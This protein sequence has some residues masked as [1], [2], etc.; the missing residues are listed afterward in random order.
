[1]E[2]KNMMLI[3]KIIVCILGIITFSLTVTLYVKT[4]NLNFSIF[5]SMAQN[6]NYGA[7]SKVSQGT[8]LFCPD[9]QSTL[10]TEKWPGTDKG[11]FKTILIARSVCGKTGITVPPIEPISYT[12]W[13]GVPLCTERVPAKYLDLTVA[14]NENE[15][16]KEMRSCG[17]I[18]TLN[19]VM[20]VPSS[21]PC[22][23]NYMEIILD[24]QPL[25]TGFNFTII[26]MKGT[27][28][29]LSN[30]NTKGKI[31]VDMI[32]SEDIPC[33]DPYDKN[34]IYPPYILEKYFERSKCNS[35]IGNK[36]FDTDYEVKDIYPYYNVYSENNIL[37]LLKLIPDFLP[38]S[39]A[40][41]ASERQMRLYSKNYM[42]IK[43]QCIKEIKALNI[44]NQLLFDM[45]DMQDKTEGSQ[46]VL[47][48]SV[49]FGG[50]GLGVMLIYDATFLILSCIG[51][52]DNG[53]S[54]AKFVSISILPEFL[55]FLMF[56]VACIIVSRYC[57]LTNTYEFLLDNNCVDANMID[58]MQ[59]T[60]DGIASV[61]AMAIVTL[62]SGLINFLI[63]VGSIVLFCILDK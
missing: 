38:Y 45:T 18:D 42:G 15:C 2:A 62:I 49:I 54:I 25:P 44:T 33:A 55:K 50:V 27:N 9:F 46:N 6:W 11:C 29:I 52:C 35:N 60:K 12:V 43:A 37:S 1:M 20:C 56:I 23:H 5:K 57:G 30:T 61:Q 47:L 7:V 13:R 16:P 58:F 24:G 36:T 22:P 51:G 63:S 34:Y 4:G 39:T 19:N 31:I 14:E 32:L 59:S 41:Q 48:Y 53:M 8:A 21:T 10:I 3:I 17:L 28:M 40:L 26:P